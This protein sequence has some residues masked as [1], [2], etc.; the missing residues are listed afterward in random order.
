MSPAT[1]LMKLHETNGQIEHLRILLLCV[2][3]PFDAWDRLHHLI[4]ALPEPS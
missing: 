3:S 2:F 1:V 4:V